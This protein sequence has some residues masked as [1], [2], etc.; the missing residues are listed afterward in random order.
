MVRILG[1]DPGSQKTGFGVIEKSAGKFHYVTS[2][3][4]R[5]P[6]GNLPDR[7]KI[8]HSSLLDIIAEYRPEVMAVE[9]VFFA[10]DPKAALK[11]GQARG[12]A[13][14]AGVSQELTVAEYAP[15]TI[16]QSVVGRGR[17]GKEQVQHM[18]VTLLKLP[19]TPAED[20]ADALAVA[21]CHGQV[22]GTAE[23]LPGQLAYARGRLR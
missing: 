12:A 10:R 15:T 8:I 20:A 17:A 14:V 9:D 19:S 3:L 13:I 23:K 11:L 1:V 7:L 5:L 4:I 16:K 21:L 2:G 6:K 22:M 18:V